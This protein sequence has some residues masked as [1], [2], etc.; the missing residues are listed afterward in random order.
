MVLGFQR[1]VGITGNILEIGAYYGRSAAVLASYLNFKEILVVCDLFEEGDTSFYG[2]CP[3]IEKMTA[4]ILSVNP[5]LSPKVISG[6]K[7]DSSQLKFGM[8]DKFRFVHVDGGHTYKEC[9][10]DLRICVEHVIS[11]GI[12]VVDDYVHPYLPEVT[13]AVDDFLNERKDISVISDLNRSKDFG[14]NIY[15]VKKG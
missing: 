2:I 5:G 3:T 6:V 12:I 10:S 9:L 13:K 4:N 15:L 7:G 14:R 8:K 1:A 11:D